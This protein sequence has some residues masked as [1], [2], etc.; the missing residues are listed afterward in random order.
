MSEEEGLSIEDLQE[1]LKLF[2]EFMEIVKG[3]KDIKTRVS[4]LANPENQ[5]TMSILNTHETS[6]VIECFWASSV[7][8]WGGLFDPLKELATEKLETNI[9]K[10]GRG[11]DQVIQF[12]GALSEVSTLKKMGLQIQGTKEKESRG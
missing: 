12:V 5:K 6:F 10:S 7:A 8:S 11:R 1:E 2:K 4:V 9:S 3:R